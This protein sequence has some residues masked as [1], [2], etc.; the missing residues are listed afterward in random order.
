MPREGS[1]PACRA[2]LRASLSR[3]IRSA[4]PRPGLGLPVYRTRAL[5]VKNQTLKQSTIKI[6]RS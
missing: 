6:S 3:T 1:E 2:T 4:V 5:N